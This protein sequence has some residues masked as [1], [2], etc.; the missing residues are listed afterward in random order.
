[1]KKDHL[2][3]KGGRLKLLIATVFVVIGAAS[4]LTPHPFNFTP[5]TAI[6]LFGSVYLPKKIAL[7]LPLLAM[8]ISD[9]F[10]GFY[11]LSLMSFVYISFFLCVLLGFWLRKNK[12]WYT[13]LGSA[14]SCS[15]IF[16]L[17]TNFA[18]WAFTNWYPKDFSGFIECY[19]MALPFF[20]NTL[21]GDLLYVG[22]FFGIYE[23]VGIWVRKRFKISGT[24]PVSINQD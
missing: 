7:G 16:F 12:K 19:L 20:K 17:L 14:L 21:L 10:I 5:I 8:L 24:V 22:L 6:A 18:V 15:I 3:K 23:G 2:S 9:F 13:T 11:Q 1:M 4:R